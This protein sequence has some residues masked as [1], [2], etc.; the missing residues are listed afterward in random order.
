VNDYDT[1][2]DDAHLNVTNTHEVE[3]TDLTVTKLWDDENNIEKIRPESITIYLY[4]NGKLI[5]TVHLTK[6]NFVGTEA[7]EGF[8]YTLDKWTY[9][10]KDL[11]KYENGKEIVYTCSEEIL[12]D[13]DTTYSDDTMTITNYRFVQHYYEGQLKVTKIY[14]ENHK[15]T[16]TKK[17]FFVQLFE[18]A[19]MTIPYGEITPI[20]MKGTSSQTIEMTVALADLGE[21]KT[22][23]V[24]EVDEEGN[25][26]TSHGKL[27]VTIDNPAA[28]V[29]IDFVP[30]VT[31]TNDYEVVDTADSSS[32]V[33]YIAMFGGCIALLFILLESKKRLADNN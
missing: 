10:W 8:T 11:P 2:Y 28:E 23:Y 33:T 6:D 7:I 1:T 16:K 4:A 5:D 18:D 29:K 31:I 30:E 13:Y 22:Y 12:E 17:V 3:L 20:A 26:V 24:A 14:K 32:A 15:A 9:T 27:T 21:P 19:E 25:I